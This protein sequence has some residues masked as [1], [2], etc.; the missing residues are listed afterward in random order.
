MKHALGAVA[1]A[2]LFSAFMSPLAAE[3]QFGKSY[4]AYSSDLAAEGFTPLS[5]SAANAVYGMQKDG[6]IYLCFVLDTG[7][8]QNVRQSAL[9]AL[10]SLG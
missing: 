7:A 1:A 6:E 3:M 9:L 10:I 4:W 5:A 2:G 8:A